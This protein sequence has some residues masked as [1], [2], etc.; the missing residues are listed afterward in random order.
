[1]RYL[2]LLGIDGVPAGLDGLR[3]ITGR[4]LCR[5]PFENISKL[6]LFEREG[7]A[8]VFTLEEFLDGIEYQDLGGTCHNSNPHLI[9]LLRHLGYEADLLAADMTVPNCHTSIR[10][11][12]ES[13]PYHVDCGYGGP[14]REPLR[15]DAV[16][17]DFREGN[18]RYVFDRNA[19]P[20]AFEMKVFAGDRSV[21]SYLVHDPPQ[22]PE[23]FT[24]AVV[25]SFLPGRAFMSHLRIVKI[26]E[27]HSVELFDRQLTVNRAGAAAVTGLASLA[28][29][30]E[31]LATELA[32][33][34]CPIEP[35]LAVLERLTGQPFFA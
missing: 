17:H 14:F 7:A 27:H 25:N 23:F 11:R 4:H 34:R 5:V 35:A 1:M 16:P 24:P 26:F 3:L 20:N 18:L 29:L 19:H 2:R 22:M 8:R 10:V 12:L 6:L 21:H 32:M 33:P 9:G 30:K 13:V 15:L 31:A 28:E